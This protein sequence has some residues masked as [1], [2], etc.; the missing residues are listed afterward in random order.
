MNAVLPG[1]IQTPMTANLPEKVIQMILFQIP[2]MRMGKPE[3][4]SSFMCENYSSDPPENCHLNVKKLPKTF[5]F[6]YQ[7]L[8]L[9]ILLKK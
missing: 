1:F 5:F 6:N 7:K 8:S 9:V 4:K 3:G 2:L